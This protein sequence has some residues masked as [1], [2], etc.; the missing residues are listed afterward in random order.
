MSF[1]TRKNP[2]VCLWASRGG[3]FLSW[4]EAP[5]LMVEND[6][7]GVDRDLSAGRVACPTC[8]GVLG[9][10]GWARCRVLRRRDG[11]VWLRPRRG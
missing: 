1:W 7:V 3:F 8:E 4:C 9:P 2:P 11:S 5:V 6:A 10:W